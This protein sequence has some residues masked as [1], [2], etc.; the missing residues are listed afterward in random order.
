MS[1]PSSIHALGKVAVLFGGSSAEREISL[2]SGTAVLAALRE[3]GVNAHPFDPSERDLLELKRDG[4]DRA[5]IALHGRG[6]EDGSL[7]GALE[8][9]RIPYTGSG[10]MASAIAM[11]KWRTKMVW[12]SAGLPIPEFVMLDATSDFAAVEAQLGPA[13][14]RQA[15]V[16]GLVDRRDQG[17]PSR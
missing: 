11:D 7:Q 9:M 2:M 4:Y 1:T 12:L 14:L 3:M 13:A 10:V 16:R 15:G 17:A 5:F 6:G 8:C